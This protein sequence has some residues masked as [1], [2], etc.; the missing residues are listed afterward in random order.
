MKPTALITGASAGIGL[1][2][3]RQYARAKH[4]LILVARRENELN[5]LAN[6]LRRNVNVTVLPADLS[7]SGAPQ[8]VFDA[9]AGRRVDVL[10]NNAGFADF[11]PFAQSDITKNLALLEVNIVALTHLTRLFLPPMIE[12]KTGC[13][14]N[15]ASTAAFFPGPLMSVYFASKAYVFSFSQALAVE[16]EGSGVS[17][18][19]LCPGPTHSEFQERAAMNA[20]KIMDGQ[21]MSARAVA[22]VGARDARRKKLVSIPGLPNKLAPLL[23]RLLPAHFAATMVERAQRAR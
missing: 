9:L 16:L 1:E 10:V 21:L 8:T 20:S 4:D 3:A 18:T 22:R 5:Q 11:A 12:R 19:V 14:F 7:V 23:G 13:I 2:L 17:V 15:V 6:E